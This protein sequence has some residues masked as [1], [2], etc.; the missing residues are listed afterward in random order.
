MKGIIGTEINWLLRDEDSLAQIKP[1]AANWL[2]TAVQNSLVELPQ[3]EAR[4]LLL[5]MLKYEGDYNDASGIVA[6]TAAEQEDDTFFELRKIL[7]RNDD[8]DD[9]QDVEGIASGVVEAKRTA[10]KALT[11]TQLTNKMVGM[12]RW[13]S[14][15][16]HPIPP[17]PT[18][19]R[20]HLTPIPSPAGGQE[21]LWLDASPVSCS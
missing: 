2:R 5:E 8:E 21:V 15:E 6:S 4:N 1:T 18:T 10:P 13:F 3:A 20:W 11:T 14:D 12:K 16:V 7:S 19:T 9:D 17:H